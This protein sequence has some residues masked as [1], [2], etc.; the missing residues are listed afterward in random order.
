MMKGDFLASN[1]SRPGH[2]YVLF[3]EAHDT[4]LLYFNLKNL[5]RRADMRVTDRGKSELEAAALATPKGQPRKPSSESALGA[6]GSRSR[7]G[8]GN[9]RSQTTSGR[10]VGGSS[11]G[12]TGASLSANRACEAGCGANVGCVNDGA[13][14]SY[15]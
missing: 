1:L 6:A 10:A 13:G 15:W 5:L 7:I 8:N 4:S 2:Q 12:G 14:H 11:G 3:A 9:G